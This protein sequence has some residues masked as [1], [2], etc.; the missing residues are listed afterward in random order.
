MSLFKFKSLVLFIEIVTKLL[1]LRHFQNPRL[2]RHVK[3]L[4]EKT[5]AFYYVYIV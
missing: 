4:K 2:E 3:V 1:L 5:R